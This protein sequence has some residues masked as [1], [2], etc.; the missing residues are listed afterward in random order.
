MPNW[1]EFVQ[2]LVY[3]GSPMGLSEDFPIDTPDR[4]IWGDTLMYAA[5]FKQG[6]GAG[7]G[8]NGPNFIFLDSFRWGDTNDLHGFAEIR[9]QRSDWWTEK[10]VPSVIFEINGGGSFSSFFDYV[11]TPL[12]YQGPVQG[13]S[14]D[15]FDQP[16]NDTTWGTYLGHTLCVRNTNPT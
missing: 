11:P 6:P 16:F 7:A 1:S 2:L 13:W 10:R 8:G 3:H 5:E 12:V 14:E 4:R 15:M 9:V